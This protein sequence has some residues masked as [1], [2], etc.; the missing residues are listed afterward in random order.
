MKKC[1]NVDHRATPG[2]SLGRSRNAGYWIVAGKA[3]AKS[4][5]KNCGYCKKNRALTV[6]QQMG[7]LPPEKL[8][9]PCFP[10]EHCG[11]DYLGP[12]DCID[13]VKRRTSRKAF[14]IAWK[15]LSTGACWL[16]VAEDYSTDQFLLCFSTMEGIFGKISYIYSDLGTQFSKASKVIGM[17]DPPEIPWKQITARLK[18]KVT[19]K[20]AP[21]G[22][23]FRNGGA[24]SC[25]KA[26]K[27]ALSHLSGSNGNN[28]T[29]LELQHLLNRVSNVINSRPLAVRH[30]GESEDPGVCL[31]TPNMLLH[32]PRSAD[33]S[34]PQDVTETDNSKYTIR[35]RFVEVMFQQ[36][37]KKWWD[38]IFPHLV[39]L[40]R[41]K[42]KERNMQ[43]DDIV[44][45]KFAQK[46]SKP[47]FRMGRVL[48]V[49]KDA[50]GL[51][52]TCS[53]GM[54]Q[55]REK[56]PVLSYDK[57]KLK[58]QDFPVQRLVVLLAADEEIIDPDSQFPRIIEDLIPTANH[59][60]D[61]SPPVKGFK[62]VGN[63]PKHTNMESGDV[64]VE[65]EP[66]QKDDLQ[67][68][69]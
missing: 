27:H 34:L 25:V 19:W 54:R 42:F 63:V 58:A 56:E 59:L 3:I 57:K 7:Q 47:E 49:E 16:T 21:A 67:N 31:I 13:G 36:W 10:F 61:N 9:V 24:E 28:L 37:W 50:S 20:L 44:L 38:S 35:Y 8:D 11:V 26:C 41:W 48:S 29:Q 2:D 15:C 51:V 14:I 5:A 68:S 30:H 4:I 52:R 22:A 6:G 60:C 18:G 45:V 66:E 65:I 46:Y 33:H 39:P 43:V 12:Y 23:A 64:T 55:R 40:K 69:Q 32:G 53:V 1:H 62:A 17:N